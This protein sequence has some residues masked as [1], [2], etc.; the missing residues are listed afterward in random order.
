MSELRGTRDG[1]G[2][3][4]LEAGREDERVCVVD[5]DLFRSTRTAGFGDRSVR[6]SPKLSSSSGTPEAL[7]RNV[8]QNTGPAKG[9]CCQSRAKPAIIVA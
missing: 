9:S 3:G 7:S 2:Q 5:C 6:M 4:L 1:Y 8:Y